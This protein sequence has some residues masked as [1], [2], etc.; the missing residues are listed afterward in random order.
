MKTKLLTTLSAVLL[1]A[2]TFTACQ[3]DTP[4]NLSPEEE[5]SAT[6]ASSESDAES[7]IAFDDV[8]NNVMGVNADVAL[9]GTGIFGGAAA[10][11]DGQLNK[12][13][14]CF[15]VTATNLTAN[16]IFPLR[17]VIDFAGGCMGPDGRVRRGKI[18]TEYS[19]RLITPGATATTTFDGYFLDSIKIEGTHKITNTSTATTRQFTAEVI[20]AKITRPSGNYAQRNGTRIVTQMEGLGTPA[21]A[22]DDVFKIEGSATGTVKRGSRIIAWKSEIVEP[23]LKRFAC[24]WITKGTITVKR[25]TLAST[26]PWIATLDYGNGECDNK[27]SLKINGKLLEIILH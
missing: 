14:A 23:L 8:F 5:E 22:I 21:I 27:A 7:E 13:T 18:I 15:T 24:R 17:I 11:I 20:N 16:Q 9:G 3:K 10:G 19:N 4:S 6:L 26:S 12:T 1:I 25:E 2:I